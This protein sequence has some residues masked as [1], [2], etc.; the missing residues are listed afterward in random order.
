MEAQRPD[1]SNEQVDINLS[2][3]SEDDLNIEPENKQG[4]MFDN[5]PM[6]SRNKGIT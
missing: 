2:S 1:I 5:M 3:S 6:S 4:E